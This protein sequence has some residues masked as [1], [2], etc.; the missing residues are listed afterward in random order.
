MVLKNNYISYLRLFAVTFILQLVII[1]SSSAQYSADVLKA[2]YLERITRFIEWPLN[3]VVK[4][5][6]VFTIGVYEDSD[7]IAA[8][9]EVFKDKTIKSKK[10][11]I[12]NINIPDQLRNCDICYISEKGKLMLKQYIET[13]NTQGVL[14][15]SESK[16]FGN[17]G[18]HIN[19]YLEDDKL[20]FEIN[21]QSIDTG[22]FKVSSLLFKSAKIIK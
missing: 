7:F 22:R 3:H 1:K 8:L 11:I 21:R 10:V 4:D 18:I 6:T 19:F 17:V 16:D 20:K 13:A 5:T 9:T 14:L 15:I 12:I 2:A